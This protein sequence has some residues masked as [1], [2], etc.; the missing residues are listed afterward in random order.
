MND[1]FEWAAIKWAAIMLV[2]LGLASAAATS[3][4]ATVT[5]LRGTA[6]KPGATQ[7]SAGMPTV[8]RG[9]QSGSPKSAETGK[10]RAR[11]AASGWITTGGDTLWMVERRGG[12]IVGCW[13]QGSTQAGR[14]EIRCARRGWR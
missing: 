12:Q 13:L 14:T 1:T 2:G 11:R 5:V 10:R 9:R 4:E 6:G 8:L 7:A 3:A